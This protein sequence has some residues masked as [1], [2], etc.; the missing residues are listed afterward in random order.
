MQTEAEVRLTLSISQ[1]MC[2][3][4]QLPFPRLR[5]RKVHKNPEA[6]KNARPCDERKSSAALRALE[7]L[8]TR[9]RDCSP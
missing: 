4:S 2:P 5:I 3:R 1:A 9:A 6:V 7:S 8:R